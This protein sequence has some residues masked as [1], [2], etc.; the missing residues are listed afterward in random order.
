MSI[1]MPPWPRLL[2]NNVQPGLDRIREIVTALRVDMSALPPVIHV[3]GT[4]GKGSTIAYLGE[5]FKNAKYTT[6]RYISPHLMRF[7]ERIVIR[8][9][10][11][12]DEELEIL[13]NYGNHIIGDDGRF[14]FFEATTGLALYKFSQEKAD[15][16]LLEVGMGGNFDA[17]NIVR[18][19][20]LNIITP[21]S[22]DHTEFLG[23]SLSSIATE[24]CGIIGENSITVVSWQPREAVNTITEYCE[25]KNANLVLFGRDW[26]FEVFDEEI[27]LYFQLP[28]RLR[29][30]VLSNSLVLAGIGSLERNVVFRIPK[31]TLAGIHQFLNAATAAIAMLMLGLLYY[32]NFSLLHIS[33]AVKHAFWA[34]RMQKI[35]SNDLGYDLPNNVTLIFDGAHNVGGA[36]MLMASIMQFKSSTIPLYV[37]HGRTKGRDIEGFLRFFQIETTLLCVT[38][39]R[40][41]PKSESSLVLYDKA[42]KMGFNCKIVED[43]HDGIRECLSHI[44]N[45]EALILVCGSLYLFADIKTRD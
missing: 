26:N 11:I 19:K 8:D 44:N 41:E 22:L 27:E 32:K 37:I 20:I 4:N 43:V 36:E 45:R 18:D 6:H 30:K 13:C 28:R 39:I 34:G 3:T 31:P 15:A 10:E 7:N 16:L 21:I 17:T 25:S 5:C 29:N 35:T 33:E 38:S 9:Q 14:S 40:S 2:S 24:K 23:N 42:I 12:S 1:I